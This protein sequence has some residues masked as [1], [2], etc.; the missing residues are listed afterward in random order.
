MAKRNE[1]MEN[2]WMGS[3]FELCGCK[4]EEVDLMGG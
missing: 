2:F 3:A 1:E 4:R